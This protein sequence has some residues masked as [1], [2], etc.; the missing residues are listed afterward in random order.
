MLDRTSWMSIIRNGCALL[1][2]VI[3]AARPSTAEEVAVEEQPLRLTV[4]DRVGTGPKSITLPRAR[5]VNWNS[6][7]TAIIVCDMWDRHWCPTATGR[8][9]EIAPRMNRVLQEARARGVLII[10][11]PSG[12]LAYYEGTPQRELARQAPAVPTDPPLRSWCHLMP[13]L[14]GTLPIDDSDEGNDSPRPIKPYNAW[15]RQTPALEIA[16]GDAIT[17]SAEAYFLIRQQG[18]EHVILMGVHTNMCVLGRP[19]G[20]RQLVQQGVDVVL[21]RDLT[22]TMYNPAMP[23]FVSHFGGTDL[24]IAHIEENWCPTV[25]SDQIVGG[26]PL[27][28]AGD[29]RPRLAVV[30]AEDEYDTASTLP[31]FVREAL[32]RDFAVQYFRARPEG[33][34]DVPGL[35]TM[36]DDIDVLL[37][38]VRR[39]ALPKNQLDAIRR[40]IKAGKPVVAIRTSSHA[41]AL[42][43]AEPKSGH[44]VWP[45]FDRDVLG[46]NYDGHYSGRDSDDPRGLVRVLGAA[47]GHPILQGVRTDEFQVASTLY[48]SAPLEPE[49]QPLMVGRALGVSKPEPV[50]WTTIH[51][52]GG[53][54]FY[55]SMG[56]PGDFEIPSVRTLL[57]NG[58]YWTAGLDVPA[59]PLSISNH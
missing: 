48:R 1:L 52:G 56:H 57:R 45:T 17:D 7:E 23:P 11:A 35:D 58:I 38:S 46:C 19:F 29:R 40:H 18:I 43:N 27:R 2:L 13:D 39:R 4:R 54:V 37:L 22:D 42:R 36:L 9:G 28:F 12:T 21:M 59:E 51:P 53:R 10:H 33:R 49:A 6:S 30:I 8:V 55:T 44:D 16:E 5:K 31:P 47:Y 24:I 20:I 3:G 41:F 32:E 34:N 26:S 15:S 14:E 25:T 50:A